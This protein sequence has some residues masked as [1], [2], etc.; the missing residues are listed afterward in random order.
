MPLAAGVLAV[1]AVGCT[2]DG[3]RS[4]TPTLQASVTVTATATATSAPPVET[5]RTPE[6][7]ATQGPTIAPDGRTPDEA[8]ND[9]IESVLHDDATT[10]EQRYGYASA[11]E[12]ERSD[13]LRTVLEVPAADWA[14][15]LAASERSLYAVVRGHPQ[16]TPLRDFN[17]VIAVSHDGEREGWRF[18]VQRGR[19][20]DIFIGSGAS[21]SARVPPVRLVYDRFIVLPPADEL[22]Q[23][24]PG[25]ELS[26]RTGDADVDGLIALVEAHHAAGLIA[27]M[28]LG[29][30]AELPVRSCPTP[31]DPRDAEYVRQEL[32][33]L[34][35]Q[36]I[37]LHA[38]ADLPDGY[39]PAGDHLLIFVL[40]TAP[41]DWARIGVIELGGRVVA[42][43]TS[44]VAYPPLAFIVPPPAE[45]EELEPG[46][47][48]GNAIV[49][50]VLDA[51]D[52][53]DAEALAELIDYEQIGC[54]AEHAGIG[55]PPTCL[56]GEAP[57]AP[58]E[59]LLI[60]TCGSEWSLARP[61]GALGALQLIASGDWALFAA[62][63][64][65]FRTGNSVYNRTRTQVVLA[66]GPDREPGPADLALTF[67][68]RGLTTILLCG[69][70]PPAALIA[71]G[72][73][74]SFLLAPP[75]WPA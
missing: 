30:A 64:R 53:G 59:A 47:R 43:V 50:A 18:A 61:E 57:G 25:H 68:D 23:P 10:L 48:S 72:R 13:I 9:L 60:A 56:P 51:I 38:V 36:A 16:V 28:D 52:A 34:A 41:Y 45:P 8:L 26:V 58:V 32:T 54:V 3:S 20:V 7:L 6:P 2:S 19:F 49:D 71:P 46:R 70:Y 5:S 62:V 67:S 27:S 69:L 15:R 4:E 24:P 74:P 42:L 63:D 73:A 35:G 75:G 66:S 14:S 39:Q 22:P 37:S 11:R 29:P 65:G 55:S 44:C 17:V 21:P 40:S 33:T 1:V 12:F 31:L